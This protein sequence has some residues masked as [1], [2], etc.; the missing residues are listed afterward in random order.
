MHSSSLIPVDGHEGLFRDLKTGCIIN[1]D[2]ESYNK[3]VNERNLRKI[4]EFKI[5]NTAEEVENLKKEIGEIKE[6][7]LKLIDANS[8]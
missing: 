4:R 6:L 2:T 5:E 1:A 3:Y 8:N 7:I